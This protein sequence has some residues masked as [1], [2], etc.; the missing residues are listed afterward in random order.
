MDRTENKNTEAAF[1]GKWRMDPFPERKYERL[2]DNVVC[3]GLSE[4]DERIASY[5]LRTSLPDSFVGLSY[6]YPDDTGKSEGWMKTVLS[7]AGDRKGKKKEQEAAIALAQDDGVIRAQ[8]T[9]CMEQILIAVQDKVM[10]EAGVLREPELR[11]AN[12]EAAGDVEERGRDANNHKCQESGDKAPGNYEDISR[13]VSKHECTDEG[14]E[15]VSSSSLAC[16]PTSSQG[17][18]LPEVVEQPVWGIDCYTRRNITI[19][20][21]TEFDAQTALVFIEKWLLPAIN[22]CPIELAHDIANA[23]LILEG[24]PFVTATHEENNSDGVSGQR[25]TKEAKGSAEERWS[26]SLIGTALMNKIK[27]SGPPWLKLAARLLRRARDAL[28]PDFFRVHP[29]GHGSVV[30]SPVLAPNTL[31]TFY[32]GEVYPSWRWGEKMDAIDIT[33]ARKKLKPNLPDFYNMALE[34]PQKDPRKYGL[35]FVDASRKAGH[36]SSLSHS[37]APTCEVR[38]AAVNGELCLAMTTLREIEMGEELT[39]DYNAVTESLV[40]YRSAVCLCGYGKCRQSFLHFAAADCYQRVLNRNSPI[41]V[42]F[43]NLAKGCMKEVMSEE[44]ERT[45]RNHGFMTAAFGAISV[46][47]H[48]AHGF[49]SKD[50]VLDSMDIV[51]VWLRTYV[52][53]TL[54][55][56][57]Y[58]RRALP[59]ALICDHFE[60]FSEPTGDKAK[61]DEQAAD[62]SSQQEEVPSDCSDVNEEEDCDKAK[63]AS[64]PMPSFFFYSRANKALFESLVEKQGLPKDAKGIEVRQAVQKTAASHWK[65]LSKEE[66][67]KWKKKAQKDWEKNVSRE[68]SAAGVKRKHAD[69]N[70]LKKP[71]KKV[72]LKKP[73]KKARKSTKKKGE[74]LES[75]LASSN[76]SFQAADAEGISAL[77]QRIQ[78]L[79]QALSRVGRV[80]DRHREAKF[81]SR[82]NN[83]ETSPSVLRNQVHPPLTIATDEQVVSWMWNDENGIVKA[84]LVKAEAEPC[85]S[86]LLKQAFKDIVIKYEVLEKFGDP[87]SDP[88]S[89]S[90]NPLKPHI[91]RKKLVTALLELRRAILKDLKQMAK[92]LKK[93]KSREKAARKKQKLAKA[94]DVEGQEK[95]E[96]KK[97]IPDA[98]VTAKDAI[99]NGDDSQNLSLGGQA[100][101]AEAIGSEGGPSCVAEDDNQNPSLCAGARPSG[102][103]QDVI[104]QDPFLSAEANTVEADGPEAKPNCIEHKSSGIEPPEVQSE[105]TGEKEKKSSLDIRERRDSMDLMDCRESSIGT[106]GLLSEGPVSQSCEESTTDDPPPPSSD[107]PPNRKSCGNTAGGILALASGVAT[108]HSD[109]EDDV[110]SVVASVLRDL[111]DAVVA[112]AAESDS[113]PAAESSGGKQ[114]EKGAARTEKTTDD[115]PRPWLQHYDQ[116]FKLQAAADLLLMYAKTSTFFLM[117]PYKPLKSTPIEVYAREIGNAVPRSVIDSSVTK[118]D[119]DPVGSIATEVDGNVASEPAPANLIRAKEKKTTPKKELEE[120]KEDLCE[121]DDIVAEVTVKYQGDFVLSQLLQWYNG[122]IGQ[123]PGLPEM[124]GCIRLPSMSGCWEVKAKSKAMKPTLYETKTRPHLVS[125]FSD[126]HQRGS[127]WPEDIQSAFACKSSDQLPKDTSKVFLPLGSPVLDLLVTG[128]DMN[129]TSILEEFGADE[130]KMSSSKGLLST[131]DQ[132]RPAQAVSNWVQCENPDCG[133]WRKIPWHVDIDVLAKKFV[134]SDNIWNPAS[135]SCDAPED[136]YDDGDNEVVGERA[137]EGAE[138]APNAPAET[139]AGTNSTDKSED[140]E[141]SVLNLQCLVK[142]ARFDVLRKGKARYYVGVVID[143]NTEGDTKRVKFRF[144]KLGRKCDEWVEVGSSQIAPL[145]TKVQPSLKRKRKEPAVSASSLTAAAGEIVPPPLESTEGI[146]KG[147]AVMDAETPVQPETAD[148]FMAVP[149]EPISTEDSKPLPQSDLPVKKRKYKKRKKETVTPSETAPDSSSMIEG[150]GV[151]GLATSDSRRV[152]SNETFSSTREEDSASLRNTHDPLA[153]L[154]AALENPKHQTPLPVND[155]AE[156]PSPQNHDDPSSFDTS[157]ADEEA[158]PSASLG[159]KAYAGDALSATH[160]DAAKQPSHEPSSIT[161]EMSTNADQPLSSGVKPTLDFS[162]VSTSRPITQSSSKSKN[163][164][165][166]RS[167]S[168]KTKTAF[169]TASNSGVQE[170]NH[171]LLSYDGRSSDNRSSGCESRLADSRPR[172][173]RSSEQVPCKAPLPQEHQLISSANHWQHEEEQRALVAHQWRHEEEQ[174]AP[175]GHSWRQEGQKVSERAQADI[176]NR[177][178]DT[179]S[180]P[181]RGVQAQAYERTEG[182]RF[183]SQLERETQ[184]FRESAPSFDSAQHYGQGHDTRVAPAPSVQDTEHDQGPSSSFHNANNMGIHHQQFPPQVHPHQA[185]QFELE[186]IQ[187]MQNANHHNDISYQLQQRILAALEDERQR[188][189]MQSV[190]SQLQRMQ[191]MNAALRN[192][193]QHQEPSHNRNVYNDVAALLQNF[194]TSA[195]QFPGVSPVRYNGGQEDPSHRD[196]GHH[197]D[198]QYRGYQG[199]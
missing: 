2:S 48:K 116:R 88:L 194:G 134:C 142:G 68:K 92:D 49:D 28:G 55:Y 85:V 43:A 80:L 191:E 165:A 129:I 20:L 185:I 25:T 192:G 160:H 21:T 135:N 199:R 82:N 162:P 7:E 45:L 10:T 145:G 120:T 58:E 40:E 119:T 184:L 4:L 46:N 51:P 117:K 113:V 42:R 99:S 138:A 107:V 66:K 30:L 36:G 141:V 130:S 77:E 101:N 144:P 81:A 182:G 177:F 168:T 3:A 14:D 137:L 24:L 143:I 9:T 50:A 181:S 187:Q 96:V 67:A 71:A 15:A 19:C 61:S 57:E 93:E 6:S 151:D 174:R 166:K 41:A 69:C 89:P 169:A 63:G 150:N 198:F 91:A 133:R 190:E 123:S 95:A 163:K 97:A 29:K 153:L 186:R 103:V 171:N 83:S 172:E 111:V 16:S 47:R 84:L 79:C 132:G 154:L 136:V 161:S 146:K 76:I 34:R 52:A 115:E 94:S 86:P 149:R 109:D 100:L 105:T 59:I 110:E 26:H 35:L 173:E 196:F 31:V 8:V 33:Q 131:V 108:E 139:V 22:A 188:Q 121:P 176:P 114:D 183:W 60:N 124:L 164:Y 27:A 23:A 98:D 74:S 180:Q 18:K 106:P 13:D 122:G 5:E 159:E 102:T 90:K 39:F 53:D 178:R 156:M 118:K 189:Q 72:A 73:A 175:L 37:C 195:R 112:R 128:D 1:Q 197:Y 38:V 126:P 147:P 44:D 12:W 167:D 125:W 32:R 62:N 104:S 65:Q 87:A 11:S 64:K 54:R 140:A 152:V 148:T 155:A 17:P 78:Q 158:Q 70:S 157:L 170:S 193:M 179:T 56:I 127:P 75:K